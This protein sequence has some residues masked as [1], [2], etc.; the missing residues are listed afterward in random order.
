MNGTCF[1]ALLN[2]PFFAVP[3]GSKVAQVT[4][5]R[6]SANRQFFRKPGQVPPGRAFRM[7]AR[8][9]RN[10]T[11]NN[12]KR[13]YQCVTVLEV[14][15]RSWVFFPLFFFWLRSR[16]A[17]K[18]KYI[19][20]PCPRFTTTGMYTITS[21][22]SRSRVARLI[23]EKSDSSSFLAFPDTC[24]PAFSPFVCSDPL[25][26]NFFRCLQSGI[27]LSLSTRPGQ[28]CDLLELLTGQLL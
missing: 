21:F 12:T 18:R 23:F 15:F 28:D 27:D 17:S 5:S 3:K 19:D 8:R 26:T 25:R 4:S 2:V 10:M 11:L 14:Y 20:K 7:K 6:P 1:F 24:L 16:K 13:P 9:G 22:L